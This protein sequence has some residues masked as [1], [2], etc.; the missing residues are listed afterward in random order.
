M[1]KTVVEFPTA[2]QTD[3]IKRYKKVQRDTYKGREG[4]G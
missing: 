1:Q 3:F 4:G 2:K